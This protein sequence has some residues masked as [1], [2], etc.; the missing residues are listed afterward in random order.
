MSR[1]IEEWKPVVGYEGLYEVSDWGNVKSVDRWITNSLGRKRFWK[2]KT[3]KKVLDAD[4][5]HI[6]TLHDANHKQ[7]EGKVHRLVAEAFIQNPENKPVVG[8]TKT[9]EN[10]LEDKTANEVWNLQWMTREE[11]GNYGTITERLSKNRMGEKNPMFGVI[12]SEE[13]RRKQSETIKR[14]KYEI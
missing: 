7:K 3:L 4:G 13:S 6:I 10:G 14:K 8:H 12:R 2:G 1:T 5:Y 11:N 9:M